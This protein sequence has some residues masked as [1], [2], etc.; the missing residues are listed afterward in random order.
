MTTTID[1]SSSGSG[2][3]IQTADASG[4]LA[5]QTAGTTAVTI[6]ASQRVGVGTTSPTTTL[7]V[8]N[9]TSAIVQ[10]DGDSGATVRVTRYSTDT[11]GPTNVV[12]KAR[13][14]LASPAAVATSD[15]AGGVYM[16]AYGGTNFRNI[17][18]VDGLVETYTSDTNIAGALRFY[19]NN[20]ST[21]V[22]EWMRIT[23]TG[24]VGIGTVSPSKKLEV[25]TS[26]NSL[27]IASTVRNDQTGTG[28]AAI[29]FNVSG[30][31]ASETTS[32]KA[33]IGL[34]RSSTY[35]VG[36]LCFYNNNTGSAG[37]FT[38]ADE[39]MRLDSTG[40]LFIGKTAADPAVVGFD[41]SGSGNC[42][43]IGTVS[44]GS[45]ELMVYNNTSTG[46][47]AQIDFRAAN[48]EKGNISWTN[49]ATTYNTSS[50]YRLKE[51]VAPMTGAL[52]KVAALKPCTYSWKI[53]GSSGQGFIAHELA[54]V[55]P[56]AVTGEKDGV[57]EDGITPKYQG[58]DVSFLV[59]T[60]TAAIQE[61]QA[62]ITSLTARIAALEGTPA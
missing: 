44:S 26:A 17:A 32:T 7:N 31:A 41:F 33:G 11:T 10:V 52:S 36:S 23:S 30:S 18:R 16:Q 40:K 4:I 38:T 15:T 6:D 29:G 54:E 3:L 21:D 27:Q 59:A 22:T 51:N 20:S 14:T 58:I 62:L 35:G 55:C 53:D 39:R 34:V 45:N 5:L 24:N 47:T 19:T 13:G 37:D 12:R 49:T 9:A 61:Q 8:Y 57:R 1:A 42:T 46:G 50:D 43:Q 60:L 56:Q 25:F 2:G 28:V 48:V